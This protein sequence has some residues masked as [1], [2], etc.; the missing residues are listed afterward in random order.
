MRVTDCRK[1]YG[2]QKTERPKRR[3]G[4]FESKH[5][6][7]STKATITVLPDSAPQKTERSRPE[8]A[9]RSHLLGML[10]AQQGRFDPH[11]LHHLL[12]DL[13]QGLSVSFHLCFTIQ[14]R[15]TRQ[16]QRVN[17]PLHPTGGDGTQ[18]RGRTLHITGHSSASSI[19]RTR[20]R[21]T[22]NLSVVGGLA[23]S[24]EGRLC[25]CS[26]Q[27]GHRSNPIQ[28]QRPANLSPNCASTYTGARTITITAA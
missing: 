17:D 5:R 4:L 19:V 2:A 20:S 23:P 3:L 15:Q 11:V 21:H 18:Q 12:H 7:K 13:P 16:V 26:L 6:K 8:C 27:Y 28:H 14:P 25:G 1:G 10:F 24:T 22:N 9:F